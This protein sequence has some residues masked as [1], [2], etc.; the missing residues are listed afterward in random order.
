MA[1]LINASNVYGCEIYLTISS[2]TNNVLITDNT[3]F[4]DNTT[5]SQQKESKEKKEF[6]KQPKQQTITQPPRYK[7]ILR[8]KMKL[9]KQVSSRS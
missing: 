1:Q 5:P 4:I 6:K 8:N 2:R 9:P 7:P 3:L